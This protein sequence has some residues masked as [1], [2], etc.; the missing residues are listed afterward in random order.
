MERKMDKTNEKMDVTVDQ[1]KGLRD[2]TTDRMDQTLEEMRLL[3]KTTQEGMKNTLAAMAKLQ[4]TTAD[5]MNKTITEMQGMAHVT[6]TMAFTTKNMEKLTEKMSANVEKSNAGMNEVVSEIK[7]TN[8]TTEKVHDEIKKT[9]A[10]TA[11]VAGSLGTMLGTMTGMEKK[12]TLSMATEQILSDE[13]CKYMEDQLPMAEAIAA[14]V[15][16]ERFVKLNALWISALT[17]APTN[18]ANPETVKQE[19]ECRIQALKAINGLAD[20]S[21]IDEVMKTQIAENTPNLPVATMMLMYRSEFLNARLMKQMGAIVR[22]MNQGIM[23][24]FSAFTQ[25]AQTTQLLDKIA[26]LPFAAYI[27]APIIPLS[28]P[29]KLKF[30]PVRNAWNALAE[31]LEAMVKSNMKLSAKEEA[32]L[33]TFLSELEV[34]LKFWNSPD[35]PKDAGAAPAPAP[36]PG[37]SSSPSPAGSQVEPSSNPSPQT[38]TAPAPVPAPEESTHAPAPAP[39]PEASASPATPVSAPSPAPVPAPSPAGSNNE[40]G[41]SGGLSSVGDESAADGSA[42]EANNEDNVEQD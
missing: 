19:K 38:S 29:E 7:K 25:A 40:G 35:S 17:K 22:G 2:V 3:H 1:M 30:E 27:S 12:L 33:K 37:P 41:P 4:I 31:I 8:T 6:K 34:K 9:N 18:S 21:L 39:S 20:Q 32:L 14:S 24:S 36:A 10:T 15:D 28:K 13:K 11:T 23:P 42:D 26:T 16:A 5:G